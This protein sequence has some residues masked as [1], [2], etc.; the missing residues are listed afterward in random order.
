MPSGDHRRPTAFIFCTFPLRKNDHRR[1]TA[2]IFCTFPLRKKLLSIYPHHG[3]GRALTCVNR[4]RGFFFPSRIHRKE[5]P[6]RRKRK[7]KGKRKQHRLFPFQV[8]PGKKSGYGML[9]RT[10]PPS[11]PFFLLSPSSHCSDG[12]GVLSPPPWSRLRRRILEC[13]EGGRKAAG[14]FTQRTGSRRHEPD[15]G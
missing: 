11:H 2:F 6:D 3:A 13:T 4:K 5:K 12:W 8:P 9:R 10:I 15:T 1:P 14:R 7:E